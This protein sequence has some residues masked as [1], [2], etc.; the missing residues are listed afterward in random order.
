MQG[1][2]GGGG[3][4]AMGY[5]AAQHPE[6][7]VAGLAILALVAAGYGAAVMIDSPQRAP[8][9]DDIIAHS[10][11]VCEN[12]PQNEGLYTVQLKD[13]LT[14]VWSSQLEKYTP[15]AEKTP[16]CSEPALN[17]FVLPYTFNQVGTNY[18]GE[19]RVMGVYHTNADGTTQVIVVKPKTDERA[20]N[21]IDDSP[22]SPLGMGTVLDALN[23]VPETAY[24][25]TLPD[26]S[27][28]AVYLQHDG[29]TQRDGS[30]TINDNDGK[31]W[32]GPEQMQ[33]I[34]THHKFEWPLQAQPY[35]QS[36][37]YTLNGVPFKPANF[38]PL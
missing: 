8:L 32:A 22:D 21:S 6:A 23:N 7:V 2:S 3:S 1:N 4:F 14:A 12:A 19:Y 18:R 33:E 9:A 5:I 37:P 15:A 11:Q 30:S 34:L 16:I 20:P 36:Q 27:R 31:G 10:I 35:A 26:G 29:V 13:G 28:V 38:A 25:H 17:D 24:Q